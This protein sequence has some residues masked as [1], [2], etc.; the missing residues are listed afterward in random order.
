MKK[1]YLGQEL[2]GKEIKTYEA[3]V[4][5]SYSLKDPP[6]VN[7]V[8]NSAYN[9]LMFVPNTPATVAFAAKR[10][11]GQRGTVATENYAIP[12]VPDVS[13]YQYDEL[14]FVTPKVHDRDGQDGLKYCYE[15]RLTMP[16]GMHDF[17][18]F[19]N[20]QGGS[21]LDNI[22]GG[23]YFDIMPRYRNDFMK[24]GVITACMEVS[25]SYNEDIE[26]KYRFNVWTITADKIK[27][28]GTTTTGFFTPTQVI[29]TCTNPMYNVYAGFERPERPNEMTLWISKKAETD[30]S[31]F[32]NATDVIIEMRGYVG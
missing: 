32:S 9:I 22:Y 18:F 6:S 2:L 29:C 8:P 5:E 14:R 1:I 27:E 16:N 15:E 24:D 4:T 20:S 10:R 25:T 7:V 26:A 19:L 31:Y 28:D 12:K 11:I 3:A 30:I 21:V 23:Y 13:Q 17:V